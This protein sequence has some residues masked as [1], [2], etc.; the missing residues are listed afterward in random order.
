MTDRNP[1]GGKKEHR[2]TMEKKDNIVYQLH[3]KY[4]LNITNQCPCSCS[5]CIRKNGKNVGTGDNLWLSHQPALS[6][7]L[8]AVDASGISEGEEVIF[9][10]Y[11]EPTCALEELKETARYLKSHYHASIRVN[12][13][14]LGS[15]IHGRDIVPELKGLVDQVS[16]SLNASDRVRYQEIVHSRYGEESF[17]EMLKFAAECRKEEIGVCFTVVDVIGEEEIRKCRSIA[18]E[19]QIPFRVRT[20]IKNNDTY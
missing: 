7:I 10:G 11:G 20:Y 8:E 17:D 1:A 19:L 3:E 2:S 4:Y 5:F 12:T 6:E 13:N 16:I 9:C 15:L 14:G 18:E